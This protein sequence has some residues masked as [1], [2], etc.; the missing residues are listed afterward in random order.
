M[1]RPGFLLLALAAL[2]AAAFAACGDDDNGGDQTPATGTAGTPG[3]TATAAP[4]RPPFDITSPVTIDFWHSMT[5]S[6]ATALEALVK[7]FDAAE[8][9]IAVNLVFQGSYTD[10]FNK[11]VA[12][13]INASDA[14]ALVQLEDVLTQTMVDSKKTV[15]MQEFVDRDRFDTAAF[16]P[17]VRDYF[18]LDGA[19]RS[20]P[21]NVS[22]PIMYYDA[23]VWRAAGL[24]PAKPP[25]DFDELA[26]AC[27]TL[28]IREGNR[29]K[30]HCIAMDISSWYF[31][32]W[33]AKQDALL[34]NNGNGRD[35]RAT[36]AVFNSPE[37][38]R[39]FE[40]WAAGV[41]SG[42]ILNVGI[43]PSGPDALLALVNPDGGAA[44]AIQSS[45]NLRSVVDFLNSN[46]GLNV[47]LAAGTL[48]APTPG[49]KGMVI[50][51]ASL[52]IPATGQ[53]AEE[54]AAWRLAKFLASAE[55]QA[56]WHAGSGY[57][58][59]RADSLSLPVV[60]DLYKTYPQF[61][62]LAAELETSPNTRAT[63]GALMGP[64]QQVR[65]AIATAIEEMVLKSVPPGQAL[66]KAAGEATGELERYNRVVVR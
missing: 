21:F 63:Q 59:L 26:K 46:P 31:E 20:M 8:P 15:I 61:R 53:T 28:M 45:A 10:S 30:R 13:G 33:L 54:E 9:N 44:I 6:N 2:C 66:D 38:L 49:G 37:G 23:N 11:L 17:Q 50:G 7:E 64:S 41:K 25:R 62:V 35:G 55:A 36:E 42:L 12:L 34:V 18:T 40:W 3:A 27:E 24:D 57:Y 60:Q 56:E 58:P 4:T 14:P 19:L 22:N 43:N 5:A 16:L 65:A 39:V 32:Q 47:D 51:G 29:V 1:P 52:W 48:P